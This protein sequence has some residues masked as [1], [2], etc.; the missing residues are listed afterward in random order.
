MIARMWHGVTKASDGDAY[1]EFLRA[2]AVPDY[3]S[4]AGNQGVYILRREEG[5][6]THFMT[7]TF[8]ESRAAIEQFA[9]KEIERAKYYEEDRQFLLEFE[10]NVVHYEI[11]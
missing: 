8:W 9:G 1:A 11:L 5:E 7:L 3:M 6:R 4:V 10:K 2:R